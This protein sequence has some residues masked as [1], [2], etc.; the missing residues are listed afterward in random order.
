MAASDD[1]C[2]MCDIE[3]VHV[4]ERD[5][6]DGAT[7]IP[8]GANLPLSRRPRER[9]VLRRDGSAVL[10][11][12]AADDRLADRGAHWSRDG[13]LIVVRTDDGQQT[14]RIVRSSEKQLLVRMD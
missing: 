10:R 9:L 8:A 12:G 4:F 6:A 7:F 11:R 2:T 1:D 13:D 3:W 5:T 14:W